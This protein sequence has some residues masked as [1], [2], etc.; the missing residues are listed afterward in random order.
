[1]KRFRSVPEMLD[2]LQIVWQPSP[3]GASAKTAA[4]TE[5]SVPEIVFGPVRHHEVVQAEIVPPGRGSPRPP[6]TPFAVAPSPYPTQRPVA[7]PA[8]QAGTSGSTKALII[9]AIIL[10]LHFNPFLVP[11]AAVLGVGFLAY[12]G[13]RKLTGGT[14]RGHTLANLEQPHRP[15]ADS[16][17]VL[18]AARAKLRNKP[19]SEHV[20]ELTG[21]MLLAAFVSAVLCLAFLLFEGKALDGS[22][23]GWAKFA[24][25]ASVSTLGSWLLLTLAKFWEADAGD[26]FRRRVVMLA[27]GLAIGTIACGIGSLLLLDLPDQAGWT[28]P[29][30]ADETWLSHLYGKNGAPLATY[31]VF[32]AGLFA[33]LRWW[34]PMDPLRKVRLSIGSTVVCLLWVWLM[35]QSL[36]EFP[37][38]W[39]FVVAATMSVAVQLAAPW[40]T[41]AER[42]ALVQQPREV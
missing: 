7:V 13:V 18:A 26:H 2:A 23:T 37:Q 1:M 33:V 3:P 34:R 4:A 10:V 30:I 14:P 28:A 17:A 16:K 19:F 32:F 36:C 11:L 29:T 24:W 38:P 42:V 25:L 12:L 41:P 40:V 20:S 21:S 31:L 8:A 6:A 9:V 15:W 22:N 5:K 35:C 39:G 27:A